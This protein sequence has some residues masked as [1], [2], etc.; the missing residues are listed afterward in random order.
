MTIRMLIAGAALAFAASGVA[1]GQQT[2]SE[3][4][5]SRCQAQC[6]SS[7]G[8]GS[9]AYFSCLDLC[10]YFCSGPLPLTAPA[11]LDPREPGRCEAG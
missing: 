3:P 6:A 8:P 2:A 5:F 7:Y 10:F 9:A 1:A 11:M 4:C